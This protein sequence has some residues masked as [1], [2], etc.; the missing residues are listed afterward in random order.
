MTNID[1]DNDSMSKKNAAFLRDTLQKRKLRSKLTLNYRYYRYIYQ[2]ESKELELNK[3]QIV[4]VGW[5]IASRS[6]SDVSMVVVEYSVAL[7]GKNE[8]FSRPAAKEILDERFDKGNTLQFEIPLLYFPEKTIPDLIKVHYNA[9][10]K[11]AEALGMKRL[12][13]WARYIEG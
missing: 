9:V 2:T 5:K 11:D 1:K 10:K 12:P 13:D 4:S 7:C 6:P 8:Q 3:S